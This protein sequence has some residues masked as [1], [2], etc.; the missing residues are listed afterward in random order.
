MSQSLIVVARSLTSVST[1]CLSSIA[2]VFDTA[3]Y[4]D[5]A[6]TWLTKRTI[7]GTVLYSIQHIA[8]DDG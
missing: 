7:G 6:W 4:A 3:G 8:D 5:L 2:I 1:T